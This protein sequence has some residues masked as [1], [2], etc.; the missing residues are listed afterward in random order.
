MALTTGVPQVN[1]KR[2]TYRQRRMGPAPFA[3]L[4][5]LSDD[6]DSPPPSGGGGGGSGGGSGGGKLPGIREDPQPSSSLHTPSTPRI[7]ISRASSSSHHDSNNSS[8]E[9]E[10]FAGEV[11]CKLGLGFKE[12]AADL[13]SSTEELDLGDDDPVGC[14]ERPRSR[15]GSARSARALGIKQ[16]AGGRP[17]GGSLSKYELDAA[18][19]A[20]AHER[21]D[22]LSIVSTGR[23]SRLSSVGS[24]ASGA[25]SAASHL[26]VASSGGGRSPSPHKMLLETS[27]CGSKPLLAQPSIELDEL[28]PSSKEAI[29]QD[30]PPLLLPNVSP[31]VSPAERELLAAKERALAEEVR[32]TP[33]LSTLCPS[34]SCSVV[35]ELESRRAEKPAA[36]AS[37]SLPVSPPPTGAAPS[38]T[39]SAS[40][41]PSRRPQRGAL[42][43]ADSR[44]PS[45]GSVSRKS[46]FASLFRRG[47]GGGSSGGGET[48]PSTVVSPESPTGSTGVR[49]NKSGSSFSTILGDGFRERSRSRS[50]SRE[51]QQPAQQQEAK[52]R[53]KGVFS[54]LFKKK[55]RKKAGHAEQPSPGDLPSPESRVPQQAAE[56]LA[57]VEF[58]FDSEAEAPAPSA[59]AAA[60]SQPPAAA[61]V[62]RPERRG[63]G[64]GGG[65]AGAEEAQAHRRAASNKRRAMHEAQLLPAEC[66]GLADVIAGSGL[67]GNAR[68]NIPMIFMSKL[69]N[70]P[71]HVLMYDDD[72][73]DDDDDGCT[74]RHSTTLVTSPPPPPPHKKSQQQQQQQAEEREAGAER[75][76]A[77]PPRQQRTPF[78][79]ERE[80]EERLSELR[81]LKPRR[82]P[83]EGQPQ[84][85]QQQQ[86]ARPPL[87]A[88]PADLPEPAGT[89]ERRDR[90]PDTAQVIASEAE[91]VA[92]GAVLPAQV[93]TQP[94][95]HPLRPGS[96]RVMAMEQTDTD[97][98]SLTGQRAKRSQAGLPRL[99]T[100]RPA[101]SVAVVELQP[102]PQPECAPEAGPDAVK[103]PSLDVEAGGGQIQLGGCSVAHQALS[104]EASPAGSAVLPAQRQGLVLQDSFEGELPYVPTTLPQERSVAVPILPVRQRSA[105]EVRTY[106][107]ERPRST[108]PINPALLDEYVQH[109]APAPPPPPAEKMRIQLPRPLAAGSASGGQ[110]A[111]AAAAAA[112]AAPTDAG[113]PQQ[114]ARARSP[115]RTPSGRSWFEFAEQ[116][117]GLQ[118][119]REGRKPSLSA[120]SPSPPPPPL[121]PRAN[122]PPPPPPPP[123]PAAPAARQWINFEEIPEK[124]KPARR[125]QT[126]PASTAGPPVV[127]SY[128]D[129]EECE[130]ECHET[131]GGKGRSHSAA[132]TSKKKKEKDKDKEKERDKEKDREKI[133][134]DERTR[135][136]SRSRSHSRSREVVA[137]DGKTANV[138]REQRQTAP[139]SSPTAEAHHH[140]HHQQQQPTASSTGDRLEV[141]DVAD[142]NSYLSDSSYEFPNSYS[143]DT[144]DYS[145][146]LKPMKPFGMDLDV[147]SNRS[148]IISQQDETQSPEVGSP[149]GNETK[150]RQ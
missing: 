9:R 129:P 94:E 102:K 59:A 103:P 7:D 138:N 52:P 82:P 54:A 19:A 65:G 66:Q 85:Q 69:K 43:D 107:I 57:T 114:H 21:K 26:S 135:S 42:R 61:V 84:Q 27:F 28:P 24:A 122:P 101:E 139:T 31:V 127:Y 106:P 14:E 76:P 79:S 12:D 10:L 147:T 111:A 44:T 132:S 8:P 73:D 100:V 36:P 50:K 6:Q 58:K 146:G 83:E 148:S 74:T 141:T 131:S 30:G 2:A 97:W 150:H 81:K 25:S 104:E 55:D 128:V 113:T 29:A 71:A 15:R 17:R 119:P 149:N 53:S 136:R 87:D 62:H 67:D 88:P 60:A 38:R 34:Y 121:P 90:Q 49:R 41:K 18:A 47:G 92:P 118:S 37:L 63:S 120:S 40:P 11:P 78:R 95:V 112:A 115:R 75:P 116:G 51:R 39:P 23:T 105:A 70:Y 99:N 137:G 143:I 133:K 130:C 1:A 72:D 33:A 89:A 68:K 3:S 4:E 117:A 110:D 56:P 86:Q 125:I 144:S 108:T 126:L 16:E 45:P 77:E 35:R 142:R 98:A 80:Q 20:S 46:S 64:G 48:T 93:D 32:R 96:G 22:S 145:D 5:D 123:Q 13:R 124:R 91:E 140:H 109:E 134:S